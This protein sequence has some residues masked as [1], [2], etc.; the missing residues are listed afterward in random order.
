MGSIN[1]KWLLITV[2]IENLAAIVETSVPVH[3]AGHFHVVLLEA[4]IVES[5]FNSVLYNKVLTKVIIS[6]VSM[7]MAIICDDGVYVY[8]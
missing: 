7:K 6:R 8:G 4:D 1:K 2:N 3:L 5:E